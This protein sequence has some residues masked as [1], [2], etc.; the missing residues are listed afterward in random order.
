MN[1]TQLLLKYEFAEIIP[2]AANLDDTRFDIFVREVQKIKLTEFFGRV[3]YADIIATPENYSKL[4][5]YYK[6]MLAYWIY[7]KFLKE[8]STF[9]TA[10]GARIKRTDN[11]M[12]LSDMEL[13]LAVDSSC[14]SARF[15]ESE[16]YDYM[17]ENIEEYPLWKEYNRHT[18]CNVFSIKQ[19]VQNKTI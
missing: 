16:M 17:K 1:N 10:T 6:P 11:S 18:G 15:Y 9:N 7:V 12:P 14:T 4:E 5:E 19:T 13:K 2:T 3:M 8:G